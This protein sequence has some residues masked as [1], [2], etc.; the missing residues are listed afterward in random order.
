MM[1][2]VTVALSV[3][4]AEMVSMALVEAADRGTQRERMA[5]VNQQKSQI[6]AQSIRIATEIHPFVMRM[7]VTVVLSG[8][9]VALVNQQKSQIIRP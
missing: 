6:R 4:I 2:S 1:V 5:L 7:S 9:R 8:E 3:I